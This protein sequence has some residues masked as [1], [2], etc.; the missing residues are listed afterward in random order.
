MKPATYSALQGKA[1]KTAEIEYGLC[2]AKPIAL[3]LKKRQT[4]DST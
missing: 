2:L 3:T 1:H 4:K